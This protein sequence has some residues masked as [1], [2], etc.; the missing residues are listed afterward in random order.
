MIHTEIKNP[1]APAP[2]ATSMLSVNNWRMS[3]A[4][5]APSARRTAISLR[6]SAARAS[7][8][9]ATLAH[10]ISITRPAMTIKKSVKNGRSCLRMGNILPPITRSTRR[11]SGLLSA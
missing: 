5:L 2:A 9:F 8:M 6:R 3:R 1:S 11:P 7:I 4:R 10:A